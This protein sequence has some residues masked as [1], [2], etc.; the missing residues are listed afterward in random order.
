MNFIHGFIARRDR[1]A[2]VDILVLALL[3]ALT[4]F[5]CLGKYPLLD[6]DEGRYAEI[7]RE[8]LESGDFVTPHLDYVK[9]LFKPPLFYWM[10]ALS[11]RLFGENEFA[12]RLPSAVCGF[13]LV[14][15]T[16]HIGAVILGRREGL[17]A[18]L[19][20]GTAGGYFICSRLTLID[21]P[22]SLFTVA[23]LG[24]FLIASKWGERHKGIYFYLF[25]VC[26]ALAVMTKGMIGIMLPGMIIFLYMLFTRRWGLL[27]EMR[28]PTG[29]PLLLL[30]CVP[31]FVLVSQRNPEFLGFF[32]VREHVTRF[33][34]TVHGRHE[35]FG[36]YIPMLFL[37]MFPWSF[38][39][40]VVIA[41]LWK[42]RKSFDTDIRLFIF[43]WAS[44]IFVFFSFS[45]STLITYIL[46]ML[47]AVALLTGWAFSAAIENPSRSLRLLASLLSS[48]LCI[49]GVG[50]I[51]FPFLAKI[52]GLDIPGCA[53]IG[54]IAGVGG[55]IALARSRR[56][57]ATGIICALLATVYFI[58]LVGVSVLP[59]I[60]VADRTTKK[61]ALIAR[62]QAGPDTLLASYMYEPSLAFYTHRKF[63]MVDTGETVD[64]EFGS[65]QKGEYDLFLTIEQFVRRWD[66]GEH[67]LALMKERDVGWLA[68][69]A[70]TPATIVSRQGEKVLVTNR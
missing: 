69:N 19:I 36:F 56:G 67:I 26:M 37:T 9:F 45:Q 70:K 32:F 10:N 21:M 58:E 52:P 14:L 12:A 60:F 39:L 47:P 48:A 64:L 59:E 29:V 68:K 30:I 50:G 62:Q 8:M 4:F 33:L 1:R 5:H 43:I 24:F 13:L 28:F 34:T 57:D 23:A 54:G 15:L 27:W 51:L 49:A 38:F 11:L 31:W 42:F 53:L 41:R 55:A 63:I 65:K 2:G 35:P 6:P 3:F 66:S 22:L 44:V 40:P 18:A 61:L 20:L 7:P 46:P 16:Y 17:L 25:Y